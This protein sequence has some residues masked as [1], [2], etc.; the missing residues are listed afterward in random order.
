MMP[1]PRAH[2]PGCSVPS[3]GGVPN[4]HF[5][6]KIIPDM[7]SF[8]I[9]LQFWPGPKVDGIPGI[10]CIVCHCDYKYCKFLPLTGP[11]VNH[12]SGYTINVKRLTFNKVGKS[13]DE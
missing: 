11:P 7:A 4:E 5:V 8:L 2:L 12:T 3:F 13:Q 1:K 10:E 6:S 9:Y